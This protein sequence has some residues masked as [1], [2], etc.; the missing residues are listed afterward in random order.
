VPGRPVDVLYAPAKQVAHYGGLQVCGS[1]WIC[2]VCAA[3]ISERRRVELAAALATWSTEPA[4]VARRLLLV[5]FTLQHHIGDSL[6]S[7][8]SAL[9]RARRLLMG[10]KYAVAF[11][12]KYAIVGM[13]RTLEL[14]YGENGWHPHLHVLYFFEREVPIIPFTD[15]IKARW[16]ATVK[17]AGGFA[18]YQHG[19]DVRFS[20]ADIAEYIAKWGKEPKWTVSHEMTK[21]V[22][23]YGSR[24]GRTPLQL[25]A[26]YFDG[27]QASG[28]L[29]LQ[30]ALTFKGERQLFWSHG[31][32]VRLGLE[33]EKT[34]EELAAEQEEIA[35]ILA[36][37]SIGA[38]RVVVANDARAE[39]LEVA[40]SGD[41]A[42]VFAFLGQ[43]GV[44]G[45]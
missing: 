17:S 37:L 13:V 28:R 21:S 9:K 25:L 20:D 40:A 8:F 19:C 38:W 24:D 22:S 39:L 45:L 41:K 5:T 35:I 30:Y 15:E 27:N 12:Q 32:R 42:Q 11:A 4:V 18:S 6:S 16:S 36:S 31:L 43:L 14:T 10:G 26:E 2:P 29:W 33:V 23:K 44:S 7:V 3:K 1:V 34:D